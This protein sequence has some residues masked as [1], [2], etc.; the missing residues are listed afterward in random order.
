[1]K[2]NETM[3]EQAIADCKYAYELGDVGDGKFT[4]LHFHIGLWAGDRPQD[5]DDD[6]EYRKVINEIKS[7]LFTDECLL[8]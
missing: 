5:C 8:K 7:K 4:A 1:M 6:R 2:A 3:R